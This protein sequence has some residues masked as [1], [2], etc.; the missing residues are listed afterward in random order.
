MARSESMPILNSDLDGTLVEKPED[1]WRKLTKQDL[2]LR[3]G[4]L[5]FLDGALSAGTITRGEVF[6]S[7]PRLLPPPFSRESATRQTF[8]VNGLGEYFSGFQLCGR[9]GMADESIKAGL[10]ASSAIAAGGVTAFI[11]DRSKLP[12]MLINYSLSSRNRQ[13]IGSEMARSLFG[14]DS[15]GSDPT[16]PITVVLGIAPGPNQ[17]SVL[18]EIDGYARLAANRANRSLGISP[19]EVSLPGLSLLLYGIPAY[20]NETGQEFA[21]MINSAAELRSR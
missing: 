12:N 5:S 20:N 1:R 4:V 6:T 19:R 21:N 15:D 16:D 17:E 8:D 7:R 11:D 2:E 18:T 13:A 14:Y 9:P 3:P 10:V